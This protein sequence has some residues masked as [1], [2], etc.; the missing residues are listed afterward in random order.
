[1][2]HDQ[3]DVES[4]TARP[5]PFLEFAI[6]PRLGRIVGAS[7]GSARPVA[8]GAQRVAG[9]SSSSSISTSR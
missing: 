9:V 2:D 8:S 4:V 5:A 7:R 3:N 6:T 1:M